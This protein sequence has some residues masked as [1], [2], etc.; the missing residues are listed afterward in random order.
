M[1]HPI[2]FS[3]FFSR[4]QHD[5]LVNHWENQVP[6]APGQKIDHNS[7]ENKAWSATYKALSEPLEEAIK[8]FLLA[9]RD[10]GELYPMPFADRREHNMANAWNRF[11]QGK[12][13][14]WDLS[15]LVGP[16]DHDLSMEIA[17]S[18][19]RIQGTPEEIRAK[20]Y[21]EVVVRMNQGDFPHLGSDG[22]DEC[23]VTGKRLYTV[24]S[25]W[26]AAL[27]EAVDKPGSRREMVPIREEAALP[28]VIAHTIPVPSG[29]LLV[30]DWFRMD[31]NLFTQVVKEGAP[32]ESINTAFGRKLLTQ[33]YAE[34]FG[35]MSVEV[36]NT[37]PS[38][39]KRDDHLVV[40]YFNDDEF[41]PE[42]K[43]IGSVCTDLWWVTAIDA[44]VFENVV[45]TRVGHEE[46]KSLVD[47]FVKKEVASGNINVVEVEHGEL[48]FHFTA[49]RD[50][51]AQFRAPEVSFEGMEPYLVMSQK[52]LEWSPLRAPSKGN[53]IH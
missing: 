47:A 13:Q 41:T 10:A 40:G 3:D 28:T 35:F 14:H 53:R 12:E 9:K 6:T 45:A 8:G 38:I 5:A 32:E 51:L 16:L 42:G 31:D 20:G 22:A 19:R 43:V 34:K 27:C 24:I 1:T 4:E 50:D 18:R 39:V 26:K 7:P 36:G 29:K 44:Q 23:S 48:S 49:E 33:H 30:A 17:G 46:A 37:S 2:Q 21:A 15:K 52:S 25:G 11:V